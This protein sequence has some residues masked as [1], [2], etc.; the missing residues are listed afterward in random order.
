MI[1][2]TERRVIK[3]NKD[4]T[5]NNQMELTGPIEA[6]KSMKTDAAMTIV[7]DSEYLVLNFNERL[8]GWKA[9]GWRTKAKKSVQNRDLW[10]ELDAL[11]ASRVN[12]VVFQWTR[13][14]DGDA[15]NEEADGIANAEAAKAAARVRPNGGR[16]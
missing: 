10:E 2:G 8:P 6:I 4:H 15:A 13:G 9:N 3:G 14:H 16:S 1:R 7:S 12:G 11:V 5:T